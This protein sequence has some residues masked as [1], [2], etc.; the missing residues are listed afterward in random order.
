MDKQLQNTIRTDY[1]RLLRRERLETSTAV[2]KLIFVQTI[3]GHAH[4]GHGAFRQRR[5]V[6][7]TVADVVRA[8]GMDAKETKRAR[9]RLIDDVVGWA[10]RAM[11]GEKAATLTTSS[12][13]PLL[14]APF[15]AGVAVDPR[16][17]LHGLYV[18]GLRDDS[19]VRAAVEKE[20]GIVIGGGRCY[21]VDSK[22][23][24]DME[25]DSEKLAHG[26]H[27]DR[28]EEYRRRGLIVDL[29]AD[30]VDDDRYRYLYVRDREGPGQ[31]D[32]AAF[33]FAGLLW[34]QDCALGVFLADAVDTLEKYSE[35]YADQDDD[36]S[37][38]VASWSGFD[39]AWEQDLHALTYLAAEPEEFEDSVP[40]SS[41]RY[42][43]RIDADVNKCAL[44]N[45]LDFI[46]GRPTAT[47]LVGFDRV[48]STRFY[49]WVR[50][51][52]ARFESGAAAPAA[53]GAATL[54]SIVD[55]NV[56][57]VRAGDAPEKVVEALAA[58]GAD[59]AVV[60]DEGGAVVG[61]IKAADVLRVM[62]EN[63]RR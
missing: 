36:L 40:D 44:Q 50:Q 56:V 10:E 58:S 2:E 47:M 13:Q 25:L 27:A 9:Q 23:M 14:W 37:R 49:R 21:I 22:V 3:E 54:E 39:P 8:V 61:T 55:H 38:A 34:G 28:I 4:N 29:P 16:Q 30:K 32:D 42:F 57:R 51:W 60:L 24:H 18:G 41:L 43:L 5:Y 31:S 12:D 11:A 48:L 46:A 62:W 20:K 7:L 15:L 1:E 63:R 33:V 52:L 6:D 53:V 35:K 26:A 45:H 19:A 17:V 59:V